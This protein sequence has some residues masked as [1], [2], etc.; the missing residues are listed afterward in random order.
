M[1]TLNSK[2]GQSFAIDSC[3][4]SAHFHEQYNYVLNSLGYIAGLPKKNLFFS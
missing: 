1:E 4:F 2:L 3:V